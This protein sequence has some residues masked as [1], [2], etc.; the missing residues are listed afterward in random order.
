MKVGFNSE[1]FSN[2]RRIHS[3]VVGKLIV[4]PGQGVGSNIL[5]EEVGTNRF[6]LKVFVDGSK[7][8][9]NSPVEV[10]T[11][12]HYLQGFIHPRW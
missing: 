12:S 4:L 9:A 8:P 6:C 1:K 3:F 10:G 5:V 11:L 2:G 7:N